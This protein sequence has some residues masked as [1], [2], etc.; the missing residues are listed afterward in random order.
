MSCT[1]NLNATFLKFGKY[2]FYLLI[3]YA[4]SMSVPEKNKHGAIIEAAKNHSIRI[5]AFVNAYISINRLLTLVLP[6]K[7][8]EIRQQRM[9]F[10]S[11]LEYLPLSNVISQIHM[12]KNVTCCH[13]TTMS[14]EFS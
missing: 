6:I 8:S 14:V 4:T 12:S 2:I 7:S 5:R 1:L 11:Y 3:E 10:H 13:T 9:K